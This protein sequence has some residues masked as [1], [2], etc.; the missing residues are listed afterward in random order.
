MT[1][2]DRRD[3]RPPPV[4]VALDVL[5]VPKLLVDL[6][7]RGVWPADSDQATSFGSTYPSPDDRAARAK[8]RAIWSTQAVARD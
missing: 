8:A 2:Q 3:T 4:R 7:D 1:R 5:P 6:V